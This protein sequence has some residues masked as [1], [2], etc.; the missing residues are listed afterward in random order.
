MLS[1]KTNSSF[2][3]ARLSYQLSVVRGMVFPSIFPDY[4]YFSPLL[5]HSWEISK[6]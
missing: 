4:Y 6:V 3:S 2:V 1:T 5:L